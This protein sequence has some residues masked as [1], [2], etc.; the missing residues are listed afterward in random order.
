MVR[1]FRDPGDGRIFRVEVTDK[2]RDVR[3]KAMLAVDRLNAFLLK[4]IPKIDQKALLS[5]LEEIARAADTV[6]EPPE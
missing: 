1:R 3:A 6:T 4:G 2:G 5:G